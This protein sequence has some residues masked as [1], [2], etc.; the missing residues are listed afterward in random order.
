LPI[1]DVGRQDTR[2]SDQESEQAEEWQECQQ[3]ACS[4]V[5]M[6]YEARI[7]QPLRGRLAGYLQ[8]VGVLM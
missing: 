7:Q 4:L 6:E 5:C 1:T 3:E 2:R 8:Q